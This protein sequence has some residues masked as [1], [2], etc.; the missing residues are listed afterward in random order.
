MNTT[1]PG[2]CLAV[3]GSHH[4]AIAPAA[5]RWAVRMTALS[6]LAS[7][8]ALTAC[9]GGGGGSDSAAPA[10]A[11]APP[12]ASGG[13][14]TVAPTVS[15]VSPAP[16]ATGLSGTVDLQVSATDNVG[17]AGLE[18]QVDGEAA[19]DA[20]TPP[21]AL[22]LDTTR[23]AAGQHQLRVRAR[24]AAGNLSAWQSVQVRFDQDRTVGQA[25][26]LTEPWVGGLSSATAFAQAGDGRFFVAQQGGALRVVKNGQLLAAPFHTLT[27]DPTGE[28]GLIGVA[29]HP[30]FPTVPWIYVHYTS[31]AG[32][33]HGRISRLVAAGDVSDGTETVLRDLP[34]LSSATN[35]NGGAMHFGPDRKL[36]VAVGDNANGAQ[37]RNL[38]SVF[39]KLL[40][41][42]DDGSIPSDNP[43]FS[44][45]TGL[46]QA[47]WASGLRNPFTFAFEPGGSRM[48]INDVGASSWEEINLGRAGAHYG[49]PDS[50]GPQGVAAGTTFPLLAY[51]HADAS[52][53][54]SGPGGFLTGVAIAGGAFYP[55]GGAFGS[56]Y[57][58]SY[59][60]ADFGRRW[61]ARMDAPAAGGAVSHFAWLAGSPVDLRV[62]SDGALY[63]LTRS[64][65]ARIARR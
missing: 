51:G 14:D 58:G 16:L 15:W 53:P 12:P 17:V 38:G 2:A 7:L 8:A 60:F 56:A 4:R 52:P 34:P 37:A 61:V 64:G 29:L 41:F 13:S 6:A 25:F 21:F 10:P 1:K 22:S 47:V 28:R 11:P 23:W 55:A 43:Y 24:D 42:N 20:S 59:F 3:S 62:G 30:D 54:G 45:Q 39:G 44:Q 5:L 48:H 19:V 65:I 33:A 26:E 35:H 9:G 46:A 36:Y 31:T 49:W 32:G 57:A 27:V 40:R 50:E 63:V 18:V